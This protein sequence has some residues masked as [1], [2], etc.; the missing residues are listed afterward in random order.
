MFLIV[1]FL[2]AEALCRNTSEWVCNFEYCSWCSAVSMYLRE[3]RLQ[4]ASVQRGWH[5]L[6]LASELASNDRSFIGSTVVYN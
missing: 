5:Y 6:E 3:L 2:E 1:F 4:G